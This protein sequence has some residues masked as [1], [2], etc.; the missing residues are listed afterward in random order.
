MHNQGLSAMD[1]VRLM[2]QGFRTKEI[3]DTLYIS[4]GTVKKH[5]YNI[6][7]KWELNNRITISQRATEL[8]YV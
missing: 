2:S 4:V 6:G 1:V 3:A 5:I 7:Q 8:S